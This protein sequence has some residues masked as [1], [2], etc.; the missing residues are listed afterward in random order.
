MFI[1]RVK[2]L[3]NMSKLRIPFD[4]KE[5]V[6]RS[7]RNLSTERFHSIQ[8]GLNYM[9]YAKKLYPKDSFDLDLGS[10]LQSEALQTPLQGKY[11]LRFSVFFE[12]DSN[13]YGWLDNNSKLTTS[14][15]MAKRRHLLGP[16]IFPNATS[17]T[18]FQNMAQRG[19]L[20]NQ[21][22]F[23]SASIIANFSDGELLP[24][25]GDTGLRDYD[26]DWLFCA[27]RILAYL[28]IM[29]C[30]Y[31]HSQTIAIPYYRW[32]EN[33]RSTNYIDFIPR[34][35]MD[36]FFIWLRQ[37]SDGV[38]LERNNTNFVS[39]FPTISGWLSNISNGGNFCAQYEPDMLRNILYNVE[40]SKVYVDIT[41]NRFSID[42]LRF[43]N[44]MQ[45]LVDRYDLSG[46]RFSSWLRTV[47]GSNA[48]KRL[49]IP[50]FIG[51]TSV[52]IDPRTITSVANTYSET[53]GTGSEV[54]QMAGN[55]SQADF[56]DGRRGK[57]FH[58][59]I[60][61]EEPGTLMVIA[62]L[63]PMVTYSQ[64]IEREL[65]EN[66][67]ADD[68][69]PQYAQLGYQDVPWSDYCSI[70]AMTNGTLD[71]VNPNI[72]PTTSINTIVGRQIAWMHLM[73][74]VSRC[75]G[76]FD[77]G[78]NNQTWVLR[79]RFANIPFDGWNEARTVP[80]NVEVT[81]NNIYYVDPRDWNYMFTIIDG[82]KDNFYLDLGIDIR[83]VRP[84]GKR[85]MPTIE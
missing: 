64:G 1:S 45:R 75:Y 48:T 31:T 73:G 20:L 7:V 28:D 43:R 10:L 29:R 81:R 57:N 42:S 84:I 13:L 5:D 12:P 22:G 83:A 21:Y 16:S 18:E 60:H 78:G 3:F 71:T 80:K 26:A 52:I 62:S 30:Y 59:Y 72:G 63:V 55:V 85:Y 14:E 15:I 2:H 23:S 11:I 37:Q 49:D 46:G 69:K 51:T 17:L 65:R 24:L 44:K 9:A 36:D 58:H 56:N 61:V 19:S 8:T 32:A 79:R 38:V 77:E 41:S 40:T 70:P 39:Q 35:E 68:Y 66:F 74:D 4:Y 25:Y 33:D 6:P 53:A 34:E 27:D 50:Q 76:E 67:F 54:G 82:S 47:W